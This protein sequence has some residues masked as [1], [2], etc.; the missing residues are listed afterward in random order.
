[1]QP[2]RI[3]NQV[4]TLTRK[5][6]WGQVIRHP[7]SEAAIAQLVMPLGHRLPLLKKIHCICV[8]VNADQNS[9]TNMNTLRPLAA[10][11]EKRKNDNIL[12]NEKKQNL[13]TM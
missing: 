1:M 9:V 10:L 3:D 11:R 4:D 6:H 8:V 5:E 13:E 12:F 7:A 2:T